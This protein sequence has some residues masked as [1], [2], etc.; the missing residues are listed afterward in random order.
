MPTSPAQAPPGTA[1]AA[2]APGRAR[3]LSLGAVR[4]RLGVG[5]LE[6]V[7]VVLAAALATLHAEWRIIS[8]PSVFQTDAEIH[9]FWMRRFQDPSLFQDPLTNALLDTGYEPPL[10]QFVYWV[11]S[12]VID[13]VFFGELLPLFLAPLAVWLVFKIV[14]E[15]TE[16]WPAAWISAGLFLVAWDIHRFSGGHPRAFAQ[17]IVLLTLFFLLRR[18]S[19]LAALVPP[20]GALLYPPA[21]LSALGVTVLAALARKE[22]FYVD[23][24]RALWAGVSVAAFGVVTLTTRLVTGSQDLLTADEA[25]RYPEFGPRGPMHF[26]TDST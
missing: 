26:W 16:W 8:A 6:D 7:A 2:P 21:A 13:P 24:V 12:H 5:W 25:R 11:A 17:P 18:S 15:H 14:R 19:A 4:A 3:S 22:R 1:A 23:R 10:F 20:V 9:E